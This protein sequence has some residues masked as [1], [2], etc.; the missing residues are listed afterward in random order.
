MKKLP[1]LNFVDTLFKNVEL[2][3]TLIMGCQ[4]LL[5]SNLIMFE[6]LF[7]KGLKTNHTFL[8]GKAYSTDKTIERKFIKKGV[9]VHKYIYSSHRFFDKQFSQAINSFLKYVARE[10]KSLSFKKILIVD[11]G[12]ELIKQVNDKKIFINKKIVG[13]EQTTSGYEKI[14]NNKLFFPILNVARS[15]AKLSVE[16]PFIVDAIITEIQK[17]L[18]ELKLKPKNI[19]VVGAGAMGAVLFNKLNKWFKVDLYDISLK[20]SFNKNMS[21]NKIIS[22]YDVIVGCTGNTAISKNNFKLLKNRTVLISASSSDREFD[23]VYLRKL[24]KETH[25][26]HEGIFVKGIYL[27]NS[28]FPINFIGKEIEE[29][30]DI[31]FTRALM[32]SALCLANEKTYKKGLVTLDEDIQRKII[33]QNYKI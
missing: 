16:P 4:H 28:G 24:V 26:P 32:F 31:Q 18:E 23:S 8:I 13:I 25:D 27:L 12:G 29:L 6:H 3:K 19:L 15:K 5:L 21:L 14:K 30:Y 33:K 11:D 20:R 2:D 7:R 9:Y 10:T 22:K 17:N 1:L